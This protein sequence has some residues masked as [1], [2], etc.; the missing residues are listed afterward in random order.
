MNDKY[1]PIFPMKIVVA[2]DS[3][4]EAQ[5]AATMAM[6]IASNTDSELHVVH[7]EDVPVMAAAYAVPDIQ[8]ESEKAA[9]EL[10]DEQ[11][12]AM[13]EAGT[14]IAER[15]LRAGQPADEIILLAE[16]RGAGLIVTGSRGHGGIKRLLLG[17]VSETVVRY[18]H[19]PVLV[20]RGQRTTT[21]PTMVLMATD[22]SEDSALAAQAAVEL[23]NKTGSELHLIHASQPRAPAYGHYPPGAG[24]AAMGEP[25]GTGE[26][27]LVERDIVAEESESETREQKVLD[28]QVRQ[29]EEAG[30]E[31]V[32]KHHR[33]GLAATEIIAVSEEIEAGL[34]IM[35]SRGLRGLKR[36]VTGSV[37]D[38]V[39]RHAHCPVLVV[40]QKS[41]Q[42]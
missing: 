9:R 7:V 17:S 20:V 39:V 32:H 38:S 30:G 41:E 42:K 15:H 6:E 33:I 12:D 25:L 3:S 11:A 40:R 18:A 31:V 26:A 16:E 5:Q 8:H 34:I 37:S 35:G 10:L 2:T 28:Q 13:E 27:A 4:E 14:S 36:M 21:F 19:C 22:G 29:V 23:S 24:G 1:M